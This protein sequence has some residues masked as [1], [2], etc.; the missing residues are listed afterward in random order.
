M[1]KWIAIAI[2]TMM[3]VAGMFCVTA[4]PAMAK[5]RP[6]YWMYSVTFMDTGETWLVWVDDTDSGFMVRDAENKFTTDEEDYE[7]REF[8]ISEKWGAYAYKTDWTRMTADE[9][10][11]YLSDWTGIR[12]EH[13]FDI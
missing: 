13:V 12:V 11:A 6:E 9:Y 7:V 2:A 4:K 10:D 5:E 3:F 1:K 8:H